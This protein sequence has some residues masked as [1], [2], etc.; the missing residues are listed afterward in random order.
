MDLQLAEAHQVA[1]KSPHPTLWRYFDFI[2]F[3]MITQ[4][5]VGYGDILP[6][7]TVVRSIVVA[8]II[9]T[10]ALLVVVLNLVLSSE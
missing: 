2:Y 3:S 5:T 6:N 8:Q 1:L 9:V 7:S 10:Y 4:S